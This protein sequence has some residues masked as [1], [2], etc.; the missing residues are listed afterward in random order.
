MLGKVQVQQQKYTEAEVTLRQGLKGNEITRP[1]DWQRYY[2][3]SM[4]GASLAG[5]RKYV[6]AKPQL[7]SGYAGMMQRESTISADDRS[8]LAE[9]GD[10][11]VKLYQGWG[12]P[13]KVEEWRQKLQETRLVSP[14][15]RP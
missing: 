2:C 6:E 13:D 1:E 5:Q 14:T 10:R 12:K 3:Q 11:I 15:K 8:S 9:A 4:L 7:L